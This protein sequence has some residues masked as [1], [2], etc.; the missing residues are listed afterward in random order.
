MLSVFCYSIVFP[1]FWEDEI[2]GYGIHTYNLPHDFGGS[3]LARHLSCDTKSRNYRLFSEGLNLSGEKTRIA[4]IEDGFDFLGQLLC[5]VLRGLG[6]GNSPRLPGVLTI[7]IFVIH[8]Q[9]IE[10]LKIER[11]TTIYG[12][13]KKSLI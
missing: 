8:S 11:R 10:S 9:S 5:P 6:A 1:R 12:C 3:V 4:R 2:P 13:D 7:L